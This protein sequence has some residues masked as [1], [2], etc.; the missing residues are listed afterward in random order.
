M[1][2]TP[3]ICLSCAKELT[4][5]GH[6]WTKGNLGLSIPVEVYECPKCNKTFITCP[7]CAGEGYDENIPD[8][9]DCECCQGFGKIFIEKSMI[10]DN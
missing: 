7:E 10:F 4:F 2:A 1:S 6:K 8:F 3:N 5:L 9:E